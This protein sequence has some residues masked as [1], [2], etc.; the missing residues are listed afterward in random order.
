MSLLS[1]MFEM[2]FFTTS[3]IQ[4][5]WKNACKMKLYWL[6]P[7]NMGDLVHRWFIPIESAY[8]ES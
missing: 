7:D 4:D 6:P 3:L 2:N 8:D 1:Q 5:H